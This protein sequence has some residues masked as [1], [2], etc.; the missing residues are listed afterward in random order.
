MNALFAT[1]KRWLTPPVFEDEA[2]THQAYILHVILWTLVCVP[3]PY[4]IYSLI[5]MSD[6]SERIWVQVIFGEAANALALSILRRGQVRAA[7]ILQ[8]SLFWIFLTA[9]ALTGGGVHSEAYLLGYS[10]V[11]VI[12]GILLGGRG[13]TVFTILSLIS[14]AL[15]MYIDSQGRITTGFNSTPPTTWIVS[16]LFFPVVAI[17][18]YLAS[19]TLRKAVKRARMSEERYRLISRV[20]SDYTFSSREDAN[21]IMQLDWV[22]GAFERISGYTYEDYVANGGWRAH[23]HP[24]DLEKDSNDTATIKTNRAVVTEIRFYRNDRALRWAR[25]Y[26]HPVWDE[27]A[28]RVTGIVGAVQDITEQKQIEADRESLIKELEA[29]NAE[30]E[31]FTYTVSHDL[32]SPLIT[33][34]GFL[35]YVEKDAREGNLGMLPSSI[36]RINNAADKMQELLNDL[37]ELSRIGRLMNPPSD[38]PF[39]QIVREALE[40]VHGALE[41]KHVIVD[42]QENMPTIRGDRVRLAE[43]VQNL[44]ENAIK[45]MGNQSAP[46]IQI[47][48]QGLDNGK[49][50]FYVRDNGQGFDP[51]FADRIFGLF[52]KLDPHSEGTGIGLA[53]VKRIVE[54]H[55]GMIWAESMPGQGATFY[56]TLP[57][58]ANKRC[59]NG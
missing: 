4:L 17:L 22:A 49:P 44:V 40:M 28:K 33:I 19:G 39:G 29:K 27:A 15:M 38:V 23:I 31:R 32:K 48:A 14:G 6:Q 53:L 43:V 35:G 42:V 12:A 9:T 52:N 2:K 13:A 3:I 54:F 26:A 55:G 1:L 59:Q 46:K 45:F 10:L 20:S 47:G 21:G 25:V 18:Q 30:L 8:V 24:D 11:I 41:E 50:V 16:V 51:Q 56:F 7:S 34:K 36:Q 5:K 37:L 57:T 58:A